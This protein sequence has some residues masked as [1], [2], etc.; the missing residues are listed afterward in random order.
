[1]GTWRRSSRE[2]RRPPAPALPHVTASPKPPPERITLTRA[3]L[4]RA[5]HTVLLAAGEGKRSALE[6]LNAGDTSL[7][8][9]GLPGLTLV[10]DLTLEPDA[11]GKR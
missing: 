4:G 5:R 6:R 8:A 10:T 9:H 7:P 1:M 2:V 3:F 11:G